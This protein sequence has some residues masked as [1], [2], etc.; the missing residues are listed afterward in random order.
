MSHA[1]D[2]SPL[3]QDSPGTTRVW[4]VH[5]KHSSRQSHAARDT[6][7]LDVPQ[8][9]VDQ[10]VPKC[11]HQWEEALFRHQKGTSPSDTKAKQVFPAYRSPVRSKP[12]QDPP[13]KAGSLSAERL[14]PFLGQV[15]LF[16]PNAPRAFHCCHHHCVM[17][18]GHFGALSNFDFSQQEIPTHRISITS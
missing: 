5:C 9:R 14:F 13:W 7:Q 1:S 12:I 2:S 4:G 3:P 10:H 11:R 16:S 6:E 17:S 15:S 18:K 8:P